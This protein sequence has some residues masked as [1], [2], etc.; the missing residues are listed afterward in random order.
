[1]SSSF[2]NRHGVTSASTQNQQWITN[3]EGPTMSTANYNHTCNT[4]GFKQSRS[5]KSAVI[6]WNCWREQQ[7]EC[8]ICQEKQI[9]KIE[10]VRTVDSLKP[11]ECLPESRISSEWNCPLI[12]SC[13]ILICFAW[14]I[15]QDGFTHQIKADIWQL[16]NNLNGGQLLPPL[17]SSYFST[18]FIKY[19]LWSALNIYYKEANW[20]IHLP[21]RNKEQSERFSA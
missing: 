11:D 13:R 15:Q 4:S 7:N 1:M 3:M 18:L 16:F 6:Q 9:W 12:V 8:Q 14:A 19:E 20:S 10:R 2:F 17:R 21:L 5:L